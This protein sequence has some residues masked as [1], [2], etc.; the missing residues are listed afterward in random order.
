M[1]RKTTYCQKS[2]FIPHVC[3]TFTS[4]HLFTLKVELKKTERGNSH[5]TDSCL[6]NKE[7]NSCV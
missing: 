5:T 7:A 6:A 3:L 4:N 2:F 1:F